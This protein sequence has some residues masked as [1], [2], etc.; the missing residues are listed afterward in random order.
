MRDVVDLHGAAVDHVEYRAF[1][2]V[3][4]ETA[5]AAGDRFKYTGREYDAATGLYHYRAR[6]YDPSAG[7]FLQQDPIGFAAGDTNLYR[8][9][10]NAPTC[11]APNCGRS[12]CRINA[13]TISLRR[14]SDSRIAKN[15][16]DDRRDGV[17][18]AER[19]NGYCPAGVGTL[20][21]RRELCRSNKPSRTATAE[22]KS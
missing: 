17:R 9:V 7:R 15:F 6:A 5:A 10:F 2:A 21:G 8:Y 4:A 14:R 22:T 16:G 18:H 19:T 11:G 3:D 13:A 1:G 12:R 20:F